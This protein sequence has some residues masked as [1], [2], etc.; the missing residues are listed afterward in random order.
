MPEKKQVRQLFNNIAER[1][2]LLNRIISVG[3]DTRWRKNA[4]G[5]IKDTH[6]EILLDLASG[7]GDFAIIAAKKLPSLKKIYALDISEKMLALAEKKFRKSL[8]IPYELLLGEAEQLPFPDNS[9]DLITIGFGIRNFE[10][11]QQALKEMYRVLKPG[12]KII[13]IEPTRPE[14]PV[15]KN[16]FSFY[17]HKIVPIY[18]KF[19]ANNKQAYQY[20]PT[21]VDKFPTKQEF[22][23]LCKPM[24]FENMYYKLLTLQ[25]CIVYFLEK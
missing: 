15:W 14:I 5:E 2:D 16:I 12:K 25:T 3:I 20:L 13:I 24:G 18:G 17:F 6:P 22:L 4:L 9:I 1:Y 11:P 19:I 23:E 21:S 10:S 7:T 8:K